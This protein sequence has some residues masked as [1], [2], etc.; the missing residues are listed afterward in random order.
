V[1]LA[2]PRRQH[3]HEARVAQCVY[4]APLIGREVRQEPGA[5]CDGPVILSDLDLA[6][7]DEPVGALMDLVLLQFLS[8]GKQD[9]DRAGL[10]VGAQNLGVV[11]LDR[12]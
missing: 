12:Q 3:E 8:G 9:G 11:G 6:V 4:R 7:G 1:S 5:P 10:V 2:R